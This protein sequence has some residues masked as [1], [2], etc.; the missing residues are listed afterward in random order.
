M[1][2]ILTL[3]RFDICQEGK[4][5]VEGV[6]IQI[7]T[8]FHRVSIQEPHGQQSDV[9]AI[10]QSQISVWAIVGHQKPDMHAYWHFAAFRGVWVMLQ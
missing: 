2:L 7:V 3:P 6:E 1:V 5:K 10:G 8:R 9:L 4:G